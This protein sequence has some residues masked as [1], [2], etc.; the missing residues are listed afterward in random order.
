MSEQI[1]DRTVRGGGSPAPIDS[2]APT[3]RGR[4]RTFVLVA[5]ATERGREGRRGV[6]DVEVRA[7]DR[8]V[9]EFEGRSATL[10]GEDG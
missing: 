6:Y 10:R 1:L 2:P 7:G 4:N 5:T 3:A 9:A 8:L